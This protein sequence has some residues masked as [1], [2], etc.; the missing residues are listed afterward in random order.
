[1]DAELFTNVKVLFMCTV[2]N[3]NTDSLRPICGENKFKVRPIHKTADKV[4]PPYAKVH[5]TST[6]V[7][8]SPQL[9]IMCVVC[10]IYPIII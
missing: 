4:S 7:K 2:H 5:T 8:N 9:I 10:C 3:S 6:P 1:M